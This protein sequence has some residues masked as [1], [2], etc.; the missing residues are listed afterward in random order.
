LSSESKINE[1]NIKQT[2]RLQ[3]QTV[4]AIVKKTIP[5]ILQGKIC[6]SLW[7][8]LYHEKNATTDYVSTKVVLFDQI[9]NEYY[10]H[11]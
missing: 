11:I 1:N 4:P 8:S 5:A 6:F 2:N 7:Y 9:S 10:S 3:D